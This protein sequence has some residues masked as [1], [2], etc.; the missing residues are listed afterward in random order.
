MGTVVG[1]SVAGS[2]MQWGLERG[3]KVALEGWEGSERV[4]DIFHLRFF[5]W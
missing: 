2:V 3:L 5:L 4:S 1:L